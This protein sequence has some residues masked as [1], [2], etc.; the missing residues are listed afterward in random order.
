[1]IFFCMV[2]SCKM[3]VINNALIATVSLSFASTTFAQCT[4]VSCSILSTSQLYLSNPYI[5][6]GTFSLSANTISLN[7]TN[8]N[9]EGA[10]YRLSVGNLRVTDPMITVNNLGSN[11]S[12]GVEICTVTG[13]RACGLQAISELGVYTGVAVDSFVSVIGIS[14]V[15]LYTGALSTATNLSAVTASVL[16]SLF[17]GGVVSLSANEIN[18]GGQFIRSVGAGV[19]E[20]S[21]LGIGCNISVD[22]IVE[23]VNVDR[24]SLTY[25]YGFVSISAGTPQI[26]TV[27]FYLSTINTTYSVAVSIAYTIANFFTFNLG[28]GVYLV[29]L[30]G[31]HEFLSTNYGTS[32]QPPLYFGGTST[33][34]GDPKLL[35]INR[36]LTIYPSVAGNPTRPTMMGK[37][38][39]IVLSTA[40]MHYINRGFQ[41][42]VSGC[43]QL[44]RLHVNLQKIC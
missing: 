28:P 17:V 3:N 44:F 8:L 14:A 30:Q 6:T 19:I 29:Q 4:D 2:L 11:I 27:G 23:V 9:I 38:Y 34:G 40:Q 36:Q 21:G 16:S 18:I 20:C 22:S 13:A 7:A 1:M 39:T 31:G 26:S 32:Q 42:L 5:S 24:I 41:N 25:P 10:L 15:Q 35:P 43:Q 37:S 12:G 33:N